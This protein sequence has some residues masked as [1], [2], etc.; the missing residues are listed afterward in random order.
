MS[1]MIFSTQIVMTSGIQMRSPVIRYF[2]TGPKMKKPGLR[3]AGRVAWKNQAG[4]SAFDSFFG[5]DFVSVFVSAVYSVFESAFFSAGF[6]PELLKSVAYQPL[7][8]SWNPAA[9]RSFLY[10]ALLHA[11]QTGTG[12]SESF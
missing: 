11:G 4:A 10:E 12:A 2:F 9:L 5:S 3:R 6:L 7:P 8:L 1:T